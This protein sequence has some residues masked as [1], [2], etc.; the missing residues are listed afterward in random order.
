MK[1]TKEIKII[2]DFSFPDTYCSFNL[3]S[4]TTGENNTK[5]DAESGEMSNL[6]VKK[7]Q[8]ENKWLKKDVS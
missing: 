3:I 7:I 1:E 2:Q 6:G 4:R 8:Q 5:M